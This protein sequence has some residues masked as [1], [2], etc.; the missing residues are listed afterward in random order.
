MDYLYQAEDKDGVRFS[1]NL[2]P[3]SRIEYKKLVAPLACMYSPLKTTTN[4]LQM[5]YNPISCNKC[6]A[7]LN[8]YCQMEQGCKFWGCPF[9]LQR[10]AFPPSYQGISEQNLPAELLPECTTIEYCQAPSAPQPPVFLFVVD[11]TMTHPQEL[12]ALKDAILRA[13]DVLPKESL[14]GFITYGSTV[15]VYDLSYPWMT[16]CVCF[17]GS[18]DYTPAEVQKFLNMEGMKPSTEYPVIPYILPL[19]DVEVQLASILEELQQDPQ[20]YNHREQRPARATGAAI[21][22]ALSLLQQT[23][24]S[25][26]GRVM[27]MSGGPITVGPG[28]I[29][30]RDLKEDIRSHHHLRQETAKHVSSATKYFDALGDRAVAQGHAIDIFS[31]SLDE[32]GIF[33][34]RSLVRKTGGI[35]INGES[36]GHAPFKESLFKL[37]NTRLENGLLDMAFDGNLSVVMSPELKVS[38]AIGHM[39]S[40]NVKNSHVADTT[41]GIGGTSSWKICTMNSGSS[42]ALYFDIVNAHNNP[43]PENKYGMIQF[44]TTYVLPSGTRVTRV[45]T[46]AHHWSPPSRGLAALVPLFDQ[47]AT[48]ALVAR[49]VAHKTETEEQDPRGWLDKH[50]I[51]ICNSFGQFTRDRPDS[52]RLPPEFAMYP[53]F[54][55]HFRRGNLCQVFGNSPDETTYFRHY[56]L[57]E[58]VS[59]TLT[60]VQPSLDSYSLN[61][62]E[63]VPVLLSSKSVKLDTMLLLDTFF[64]IVVFSGET[65]AKWRAAKYHEQEGY[66]NLKLLMEAPVKDASDIMAG[67]F[68]VPLYVACDSGGSQARFLYAVL[69]PAETHKSTAQPGVGQGGRVGVG[70]TGEIMYTED[71]PLSVFLSHLYKKAVSFEG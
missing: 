38:G 9:C 67:R 43:I 41:I 55:F 29:V 54:I 45:T 56:M 13:V 26:G 31:C 6:S 48:L 12:L 23:Y 59:N 24:P 52:F 21:S 62:E 47:E 14:V 40:L 3:S 50:L 32:I 18:K 60:M 44:K 7:V 5:F 68:P 27:V 64:H 57:R 51:Q 17:D 58:N 53:E 42:F 15:Q 1:Y 37:F 30:G 28:L 19:K 22:V 25:R 66:E 8:P 63:P 35:I 69:D 46:V 61:E 39:Q 34:M 71:V 36:F 33:E 65:I 49:M 2:W 16:R 70:L 20:S 11:T 10:N 4:L